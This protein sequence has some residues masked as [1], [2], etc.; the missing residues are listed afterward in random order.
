MG[1]RSSNRHARVY[2]DLSIML[3]AGLPILRALDTVRKGTSMRMA[4]AL[5]NIRTALA[6]EGSTLAEAMAAQSKVFAEFDLQIINAAETS[7]RLVECL[8]MLAQWYEFRDRMAR[9]VLS[10][11]ILPCVIIFIA[12]FVFPLPQMLLGHIERGQYVR[13]VLFWQAIFYGPVAILFTMWRYSPQRG[14]FRM[15]LDHTLIR[16]PLLGRGLRELG[17]SR[18]SRAFNMLYKSGVPIIEG[19]EVSRHATGNLAVD[20]MFS[21]CSAK[22]RAGEMASTGM[23]RR[24]PSEYRELWQV[25][26]ETG[27][28]DRMVSKIAEISADRADL[29]LSNFSAA[30]PKVM[31]GLV[32]LALVYM[33]FQLAS[34]YRDTIMQFVQ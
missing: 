23:S 32:M 15:M 1:S 19:L 16:I 8:A 29:Y 3:E 14:V 34:S 5:R 6:K 20:A 21:R 9:R 27:E 17:I 4:G 10:G 28:L 24:V 33:I 22:T 18:Y 11:L 30:M 25:G 26:E 12:S 7:G 31:Y 13:A 2:H